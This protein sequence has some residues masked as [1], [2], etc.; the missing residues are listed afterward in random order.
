MSEEP[1][2][3]KGRLSALQFINDQMREPS[4]AYV[5]PAGNEPWETVEVIRQEWMKVDYHQ[6]QEPGIISIRDVALGVVERVQSNGGIR[7]R[8]RLLKRD[9]LSKPDEA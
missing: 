3:Y 5:N 8:R 2:E 6:A 1:E 4:G 9:E 7:Y